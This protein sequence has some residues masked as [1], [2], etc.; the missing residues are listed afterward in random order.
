MEMNHFS[1]SLMSSQ[2]LRGQDLHWFGLYFPFPYIC[3]HR[4]QGTQVAVE[5]FP[6]LGMLELAKELQ[7]LKDHSVLAC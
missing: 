5:S 7:G 4:V 1:A 6:C 2:I 3:F